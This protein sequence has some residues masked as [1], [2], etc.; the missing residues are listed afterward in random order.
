[1][2]SKL[3]LLLLCTSLVFSLVSCKKSEKVIKNADECKVIK[4][5]GGE[6]LIGGDEIELG[7]DEW[8]LSKLVKEYN[9]SHSDVNIEYTYIEDEESMFQLLRTSMVSNEELPDMAILTSESYVREM[10]QCLL[11]LNDMIS[12]EDKEHIQFWDTVT[13]TDGTILAYPIAGAQV[14]F[15]AYNKELAKEAGLDLEN[16]PPKNADEF[17]ALLEDVKSKGIQPI[18]AS[19]YGFNGLYAYLFTKWWIQNDIEN[20]ATEICNGK[21]TFAQDK[22]FIDSM[23][24]AQD[25]YKKGYINVDYATNDIS[26]TQFI[27][28]K[29]L[30]YA[31]DNCAYDEILKSMKDNLGYMEVPDYSDNCNFPGINFGGCGQCIGIVNKTQYA[32]EC[33]DFL[34][35][36]LNRENCIKMNNKYGTLPM[37]DD[38]QVEDLPRITTEDYKKIFYLK[39]RVVSFPYAYMGM[40]LSKKYW[41]Y[42]CE[43]LINKRSPEKLAETLDNELKK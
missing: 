31:T 32:T 6:S 19:D 5:W 26:L 41:T 9:D 15:L 8:L 43:T 40:E 11:P 24:M 7:Q 39:D 12:K 20:P 42:G 1:M 27:Q 21:M 18:I 3:V 25:C 10:S 14:S 33:N 4:L 36:L 28:G 30:F 22:A 38:I 34:S 13:D 23:Q 2:K 29:A 17:L 37:R 35:W 16:N